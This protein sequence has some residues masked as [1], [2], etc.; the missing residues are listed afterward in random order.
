MVEAHR[1]EEQAA[2]IADSRRRYARKRAA[3]QEVWAKADALPLDPEHFFP[4]FRRV[5]EQSWE[6]M[7]PGPSYGYQIQQGTR[8]LPG[9]SETEIE[10]YELEM[11][12]RFPPIYRAF[13]RHMNGTDKPAVN[14][15]G[16][17]GLDYAYGPGFYAY[18]RN[19]DK[20]REMINWIYEDNG[21]THERVEQEGI[22]RFMPI[23]AHRCLIVDRCAR[24][25]VLSMY[26]N[27][28]VFWSTCLQ[29]FL[30][31]HLFGTDPGD[32]DESSMQVPF[33]LR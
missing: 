33:W 1:S 24:H 2:A 14:V 21:L 29:R 31:S 22:P 8:W 6:H 26:G 30:A 27:D 10:A 32:E 3:E 23:I 20:V 13:L 28:V 7:V 12:F 25:P 4:W 16:Y 18:P 15:Y 9:L 17:S 5:S 19:L 11:G